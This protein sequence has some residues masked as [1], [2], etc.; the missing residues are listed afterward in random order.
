MS[1]VDKTSSLKWTKMITFQFFHK[2]S[3]IWFI[4]WESFIFNINYGEKRINGFIKQ[5]EKVEVS[6][7]YEMVRYGARWITNM[8]L[9]R[10]RGVVTPTSRSAATPRNINEWNNLLHSTHTLLTKAI[11]WED[12]QS[13]WRLGIPLNLVISDYDDDFWRH[14]CTLRIEAELE[15]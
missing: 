5:G 4:K 12:F 11:P 6:W 10:G 2:K 7:G 15:L 3:F 8:K 13:V 14:E 1:F 9:S